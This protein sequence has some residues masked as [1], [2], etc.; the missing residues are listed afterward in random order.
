MMRRR[1][2]KR[3][4]KALEVLNGGRGEGEGASGVEFRRTYKKAPP[5]HA[6]RGMAAPPSKPRLSR[7]SF[8]CQA[9]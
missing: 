8:A 7:G 5:A 1:R 6:D 9:H 2:R 3:G 4:D